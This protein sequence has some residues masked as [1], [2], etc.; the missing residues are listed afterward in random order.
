[1]FLRVRILEKKRKY[2]NKL[3]VPLLKPVHLEPVFRNKRSHHKEKP[4]HRNEEY[5]PLAATR[6]K[7]MHSNKDPTQPKINLK[8]ERKKTKEKNKLDFSNCMC[9]KEP[10]LQFQRKF[11]LNQFSPE[12]KEYGGHTVKNHLSF[13]VVVVSQL[14]FRP[15]SA[16]IGPDNRADWLIKCCP[17]RDCPSRDVGS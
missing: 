6:E 8:K 2:F 13:S 10:V 17:S 9:K 3:H 7:P 16:Q 12:S 4:N 5:L 1:M 11:Y 15:D 14:K